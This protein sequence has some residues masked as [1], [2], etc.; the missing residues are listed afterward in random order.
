MKREFTIRDYQPADMEAVV[1]LV[2]ALQAFEEN[3]YDRLI[4]ADQIGPFYVERLL[5]DCA[6]HAGR[7]RV[8]E[9]DGRVVAYAT[10]M[11]A[12]VVDDERDEITYSHAYL[13]DLIVSDDLRGIGLG[14]QLLADAEAIARRAGARWLRITAHA[15]N[16][17]AR[18]I[19][20]E[21][22]FREQFIGFEKTLD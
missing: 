15:A 10:I 20:Q 14:Q 5:A 21:F 17:R 9:T 12:V 19:Y 13:G 18:R 4:P 2:R 6:K 16:T 7:I 11:T 8:V 22:G 1:G 3:I